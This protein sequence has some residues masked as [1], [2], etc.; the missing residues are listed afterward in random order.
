MIVLA[1]VAG[2]VAVVAMQTF[3]GTV[4]SSPAAVT[5]QIVLGTIAGVALSQEAWEGWMR[6][7]L[8]RPPQ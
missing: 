1:C 8:T 2:I 4:A 3:A 5:G 6:S 7:R